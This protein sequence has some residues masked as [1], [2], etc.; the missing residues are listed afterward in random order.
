MTVGPRISLRVL[1]TEQCNLACTFCHN[2]GQDIGTRFLDMTERRLAEAV[3][4]A[5]SLGAVQVKFSGGEPTLHPR[6]AHLMSAAR[7]AGADD[8]VLISNGTR[9]AVFGPLLGRMPFRVSVNMPAA[10]ELPYFRITGGRLGPV[11]TTV[12]LLRSVGVP[13]AFN[14]YW[15][16]Q[17]SPARLRGL[18]RLAAETG[19]VLKILTPCH[20]IDAD[21]QNAAAQ[22]IGDWIMAAGFRQRETRYHVTAYEQDDLTVRVQRPWC[23]VY[24]QALAGRE[25]TVR[26]TAAGLIRSCLSDVGPAFGSALGTLSQ[27]HVGLA[28]AVAAAGRYCAADPRAPRVG[29]RSVRQDVSRSVG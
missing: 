29:L 27:L 22:A 10:A 21:V 12:C 23:P 25:V 8:L 28:A 24:C 15:P 14:T 17:R 3:T 4:A 11:L 16:V 26:I 13:V 6:L 7:D 18:L 1:L 2:E 19:S 20:L 5:R 9:T